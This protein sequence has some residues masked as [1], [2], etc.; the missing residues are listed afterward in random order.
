MSHI[1]NG[2]S[3]SHP[4]KN[5]I[6]KDKPMGLCVVVA[7]IHMKNK[8]TTL[9]M[10]IK[11]FIIIIIIIIINIII[12]II[13]IIIS[14]SEPCSLFPLSSSSFFLLFLNF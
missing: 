8:K 4:T 1:F 10:K 5:K 11:K 12:I 7:M 6:K 13:I 14:G 9:Y 3:L 2:V